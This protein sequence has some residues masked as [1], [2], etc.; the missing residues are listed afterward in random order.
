[1]RFFRRFKFSSFPKRLLL[2]II[3]INLYCVRSSFANLD[4]ARQSQIEAKQSDRRSPASRGQVEEE[5]RFDKVEASPNSQN[6][7]TSSIG[8]TMMGIV[9]QNQKPTVLLLGPTGQIGTLIAENLRDDH[10]ITLRVST[11]KKDQLDHLNQLYGNA[12]YLDLDDPRT[13]PEALKGVD[14][15]FLLTGYSV[16]MLAQSKTIIDAAKKAGVEHIIHLGVFSRDWACTDPHFAWHQM[17]EVYIQHSGMKWTFLHPNCF[18][19]NLTGFSLIQED[20]LR[21][22]TSK[23]CGW[24]A[25]EDVSA[26]SSKI[27]VEGPAKHQGKDYWFSTEALN[28]SEMT[29]ILSNVTGRTFVPDLQTPEQFLVDIG[30]ES[31]TL[32][33]YFYSVA[34]S[35]RQIEDGRMSYIG[36]VL[37]DVALLLLRRGLTFR[38]WAEKHKQKL[39]EKATESAKDSHWG[40][41]P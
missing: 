21:W 38:E 31:K 37:D 25:L 12:V 7:T 33:P 9:N 8:F 29:Q 27:L 39:I 17:I 26:C 11:R 28:L 13:F 6:L 14:R 35:F 3:L 18:M 23:P 2:L 34:E 24:I 22:Y 36:E 30:A 41:S 10:S 1:M 40:N 16:S 15:L 19:Q 5:D 4:S 20:K 32:D